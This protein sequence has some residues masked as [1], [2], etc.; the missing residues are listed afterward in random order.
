MACAE[1]VAAKIDCERAVVNLEGDLDRVAVVHYRIEIGCVDVDPVEAAVALD[2]HR[3][4][5]AHGILVDDIEMLRHGFAARLVDPRCDPLRLAGAMVSDYDA[6][7][8]AGEA[9]RRGGA[10]AAAAASNHEDATRQ[11]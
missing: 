3:D 7:A 1:E 8:V 9:Q 6:R 2:G 10:D 4:Q 11:R 5:P